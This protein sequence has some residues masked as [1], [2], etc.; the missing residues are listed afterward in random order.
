MELSSSQL[1]PTPE[2]KNNNNNKTF[3]YSQK[4]SLRRNWM[5]EQPKFLLIA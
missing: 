4:N 2:K 5:L 3:L 1:P